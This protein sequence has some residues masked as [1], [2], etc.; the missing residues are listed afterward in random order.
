MT[1]S[2]FFLAGRIVPEFISNTDGR[3]VGGR[4]PDWG[5]I[6]RVEFASSLLER[7]AITAGASFTALDVGFENTVF[8]DERFISQPPFLVNRSGNVGPQASPIYSDSATLKR[9]SR[10]RR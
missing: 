3:G 4:Y 7:V 6:A 1:R 9:C 5:G 8:H 2:R 10:I